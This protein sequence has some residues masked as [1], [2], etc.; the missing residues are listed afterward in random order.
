M[1]VI[2]ILS[3]IF[4]LVGIVLLLFSASAL[5]VRKDF[6][7]RASLTHGAITEVIRRKPSTTM[8]GSSFAINY[9]YKVRYDTD[10]GETIEFVNSEWHGSP[11]Y[12]VGEEVPVL[13][14][15]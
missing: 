11:E 15:P 9:Y 14:H 3:L 2:R 4:I 1:I 7:D 5:R 13:Y 6:I 12:K 8:R 10:L